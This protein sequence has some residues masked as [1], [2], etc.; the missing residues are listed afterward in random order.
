MQQS[1]YDPGFVAFGGGAASSV[2]HPLVLGA[3]IV[4]AVLTFVLPRKYVIVPLLLG[5]LLTPSGQNLYIGGLH[6]YIYRVLIL[7]GWVRLLSS[8]PSSGGFLTGGFTT[9]DKVFLVWAI[10]RA[11]AVVIRFS[12]TGAAINQGAFLLDCLGGYFL[13]RSLIRDDK[14]VRRVLVVYAVVALVAAVV[15]LTELKTGQNIMGF[16]GGI[17]LIS[18]VRNGRI[19]AQGVFAHSI[20]AGSFGASVFPLFLWLWKRG[21]A[22]VAA[23]IGAISSTIM[24]F[25]S[26]SSTPITAW[27]GSIMAICL[28]PFRKKMRTVRWGI[29]I[30]LVALQLVMKAPIW[31]LMARVDFAGGSSGWERAFLIDTFTKHLGD[32]WLIGTHD[33]ANWGWDMWDQCNQY[34]SEGET[35][36][37]VAFGCFITMIVICFKKI[38]NA[39]KAAEG[40]RKREWLFWL[41]GAAVFAETMA[42]MGVAYFDQSQYGWYMLLVIIPVATLV[43]RLPFAGKSS[44]TALINPAPAIP[45]GDAAEVMTF[46]HSSPAT[47]SRH[48]FS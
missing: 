25:A 3:V 4:V 33:N 15:M 6:F 23:L 45:L 43:P 24:V 48:W 12:Q 13:F 18:D 34:V 26:A 38:G 37:L 42:F 39:R 9:L 14:D 20:L 17:R 8:K 35:G 41:L 1:E 19:R 30:G 11:S 7:V 29:V 36:G 22:K 16:L 46:E 2:L 28:W 31:Y 21:N 5:I 27:L 47:V 40:N 44:T 10:Y 32:W